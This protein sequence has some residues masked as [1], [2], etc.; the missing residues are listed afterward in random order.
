M[1]H[2]GQEEIAAIRQPEGFQP[3][4]GQD[5]RQLQGKEHA[6]EQCMSL[7]DYSQNQLHPSS[8]CLL[9][10]WVPSL[11]QFLFHVFVDAL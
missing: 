10:A 3:G 5:H 8:L 4:H 11:T 7:A 2:I 9:A 6:S 1:L